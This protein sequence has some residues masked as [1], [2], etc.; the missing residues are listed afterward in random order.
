MVSGSLR[1]TR[2]LSTAQRAS[3]MVAWPHI[4]E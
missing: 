4:V 3:A 1:F 2:P